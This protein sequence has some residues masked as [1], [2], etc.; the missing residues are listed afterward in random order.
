MRNTL[1]LIPFWV[2]LFIA[3]LACHSHL[4]PPS[5]LLEQALEKSGDNRSELEKVLTHYSQKDADSL[6]LRAAVFLIENMPGHYSYYGTSLDEYRDSVNRSA[7]MCRLPWH[8]RQIFHLY[9]YQSIHK[10]SGARRIEDVE[11]ITASYL[12][13]N[14]DCAFEAWQYPWA[15]HLDFDDF[16]E[17]LLPYRVGN[18]PITNWRDSLKGMYGDMPGRFAGIDEINE[19]P[20]QACL[21][22]NSK[23]IEEMG[24]ARKDSVRFSHPLIGEKDIF[25]LGCPEFVPVTVLVMRSLGIPVSME[26]IE[27][28]S[29]RGGKHC[30]NAVYHFTGLHYPFTGFESRPRGLNQDYKMNKVYRH[31]Y[32]RNARALIDHT[33]DESIPIFFEN[34]FLQDVTSEYM[35]CHDITI[36][37]DYEPD[38]NQEYA[39]LCVFNNSHW[40]PVHYGKRD[41]LK[42]TFT[43]V[44]PETMFIAGYFQDDELQP[45]SLPFHVRLDGTVHFISP[46]KIERTSLTLHR[47]YPLFHR[48]A[49]YSRHIIGATIESSDYKDFRKVDTLCTITHD[50][51]TQYDSVYASGVSIPRR[52]LRIKHNGN[53]KM[54][55]SELEVYGADTITCLYGKLFFPPADAHLLPQAYDLYNKSI[56]DYIAISDWIGID[57]GKNTHVT[58]VKYLPRTD[59][60]HV[61]AGD[62]YELFYY[63]DHVFQSLGEQKAMYPFL[64]FHNIPSNGLY[65]LIDKSRGKEHRIFTMEKGKVRFW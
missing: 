30:W 2:I 50:A 3:L 53:A 37:L 47:K 62:I 57:F 63:N 38:D 28:W 10:V 17:Y 18:E 7:A 9:P 55:L 48:F 20:Y 58:K 31:T 4:P 65:L 41:G 8:I 39:Y 1:V 40:I 46:S 34:R 44:G 56:N 6:K 12:I 23:M 22:V 26:S 51:N 14:I 29:S 25:S 42:V 16:C 11:C 24:F 36:S 33:G 19:S 21:Y 43:D 54:E 59:S 27:Q 35:T 13:H 32:Q 61:M 60:N 5:S 52:Y 45:A 15:H 64:N 49:N